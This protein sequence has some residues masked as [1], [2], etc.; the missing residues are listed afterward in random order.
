MRTDNLTV[1]QQPAIHSFMVFNGAFYVCVNCKYSV[2]KS[3][4]LLHNRNNVNVDF[5]FIFQT[6]RVMM[7]IK[8]NNDSSVDNNNHFN[9]IPASPTLCSTVALLQ[10]LQPLIQFKFTWHPLLTT[11][12]LLMSR[13]RQSPCRLRATQT[14]QAVAAAIA[15]TTTTTTATTTPLCWRRDRWPYYRSVPCHSSLGAS[16]GAQVASSLTHF[17]AEC[18]ARLCRSSRQTAARGWLLPG[19][20]TA[21]PLLV[22]R[23][24][25]ARLSTLA[26]SLV[27][28][29]PWRDGEDVS[30]AAVAPLHT[31][32]TGKYRSTPH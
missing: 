32:G 14:C 18:T 20:V 22:R 1:D 8:K 9:N 10:T 13:R 24:R 15:E 25:A 27:T 11:L 30:N 26:V 23:R 5:Q 17:A 12:R 16:Q 6:T 7:Q 19:C 3:L 21:P 31:S 29:L 4:V 28:E 2:Q